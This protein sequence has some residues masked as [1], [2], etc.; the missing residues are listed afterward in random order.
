MV[1][2]NKDDDF[3]NDELFAQAELVKHPKDENR[4][5]LILNQAYHL[6]SGDD[7]ESDENT[8]Q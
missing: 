4:S 3:Y 8:N 5:A 7:L 6:L 2:I 1:M